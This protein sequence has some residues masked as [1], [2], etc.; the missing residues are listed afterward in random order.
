MTGAISHPLALALL[1][2][3]TPGV[4][5]DFPPPPRGRLATVPGT[6]A[7]TRVLWVGQRLWDPVTRKAAQDSGSAIT[8][9]NG[10][11]G[12]SYDQEP[13]VNRA[14]R[15]DPVMTCLAKLPRHCPPGDQ[16]GKLFTTTNLR[17]QESWTLPDAEHGC[18]GA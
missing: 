11:Y 2:M 3:A 10:V 4:G 6:C 13:R 8:L 9:I 18:G 12:V 5:A 1:L 15:G 14:R 17:T 7:F 16:R